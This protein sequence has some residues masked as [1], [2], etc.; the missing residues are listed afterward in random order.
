MVEDVYYIDS[1]HVYQDMVSV[2]FTD[3]IDESIKDQCARLKISDKKLLGN[4]T[5]AACVCYVNEVSKA[6]KK[7]SATWALFDVRKINNGI[8]VHECVHLAF[9]MLNDR[10]LKHKSS[11]DE[12]YA[13]LTQWLYNKISGFH[14]RYLQEKKYLKA[15]KRDIE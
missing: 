9:Q 4:N 7:V 12:A 5:A 15:G 8:I 6:G 3:D 2:V 13:Y 14:K 1:D 10:G 11:T